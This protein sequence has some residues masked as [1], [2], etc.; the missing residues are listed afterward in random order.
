MQLYAMKP[1]RDFSDF[2]NDHFR[3]KM[4]KLTV[5]AGFSCPNRD[6]TKG[7]GGCTYCNNQSFNPEYCSTGLSVTEQ[8]E[9]G[10]NFFRRKYPDMRYLAYFQAYTNT[11]DDDIDRLMSL[12]NEAVR[13]DGVDGVII[14]TRPDCMPDSLLSRLKELP[15]VMVEYGAETSHNVTLELV[16]RCHTWEETVDAVMRTHNM[17]IPCG[18]HLIMGLPG[19]TE[20][21]M[22]ETIDKVNTLPVDTV[23]V[24]QLQL[25]KGTKMAKDVE[26]GLYDIPRFSAEEYAS[27]CVKIVKRLRKD[28]AIERFVSQSPPELLIY[29]RWNLKNYQFTQLLNNKLA[30]D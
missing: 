27:I 18:L 2:L 4:Q 28:I 23:K 3:C 24:H 7:Y 19:E 25:V 1:Y 30:K 17:G 9:R 11:H 13:V 14:G 21:M 26:S 12:Y 8:L 22:M 20:A 10:K 5:N 29:P 6:G 16:N 15:W